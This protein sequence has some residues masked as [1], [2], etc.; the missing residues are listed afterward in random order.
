MTLRPSRR[1]R[2]ASFPM[3]VVFPVPFTP[4]TNTTNGF[5][6]VSTTKGRAALASRA[7]WRRP[8]FADF[9]SEISC[10]SGL[11]QSP[12]PGAAPDSRRRS[13][14]IKA[15]SSSSIGFGVEPLLGQKAGQ[16][17]GE[18][19]GRARK[20]AFSRAKRPDRRA[21]FVAHAAAGARF[22]ASMCKTRPC[23]S[24]RRN[25]R[26]ARRSPVLE[27]N[28][29]P[30]RRRSQSTAYGRA[31]AF[32][33]GSSCSA[34]DETLRGGLQARFRLLRAD[35]GAFLDGRRAAAAASARPACPCAG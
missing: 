23:K 20:P 5:F 18:N 21:F 29:Y 4:A 27:G 12:R 13:A 8:V 22:L 7:R 9:S 2:D 10:R 17:V 33:P 6:A 28:G 19:R 14:R 16:S 32:R 11:R 1:S 34:A 30:H 26:S 3:V 24:V 35:A 15:S 25:R 31:P